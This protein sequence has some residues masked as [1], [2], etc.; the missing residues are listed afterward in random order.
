MSTGSQFSPYRDVPT[1]ELLHQ[2]HGTHGGKYKRR[3]EAG[4]T[5]GKGQ[6]ETEGRKMLVASQPEYFTD[7]T[8]HS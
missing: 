1:K 7:I 3:M 2:K 5:H 6:G 4:R 8:R